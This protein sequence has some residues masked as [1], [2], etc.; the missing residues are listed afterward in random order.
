MIARQAERMLLLLAGLGGCG[1]TVEVAVPETG[2]TSLQGDTT[3]AASTSMPPGS[4]GV[5]AT[6]GDDTTIGGLETGSSDT[7][8]PPPT[9]PECPKR[10]TCGDGIVDP[11][12]GCDD[13]NRDDAD[14]CTNDCLRPS[15]T[16]FAPFAFPSVDVA[17]A[18]DSDGSILFAGGDPAGLI[19]F[20]ID[21][22]VW[23][24]PLELPA[25]ISQVRVNAVLAGPEI[26]VVGNDQNGQ[27]GIAWRFALDGTPLAM[28]PD[29][30]GR[31]YA[32]AGLASDGGLVIG[33]YDSED[34]YVVERRA[35][36]GSVAWSRL[37]E[38]SGMI[39]GVSLAVVS[40]TSVFVAGII[41]GLS[42]MA[43]VHVTPDAA[44]PLVLS[45]P[46]YPNAFLY[47][48]AAA[49]DGGA[50]AVGDASGY[51]IVV[52][53]DPQGELMWISECSAPG[54]RALTVVVEENGILLGGRR[55]NPEC[56]FFSCRGGES[57]LWMQH[58]TLDGTVFA[59]DAPGEL[60]ATHDLNAENVLAL[61]RHPD[62]SV[63]ALCE[64]GSPSEAVFAAQFP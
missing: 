46:E 10:S 25:G 57:W 53:V 2:S 36:D 58:L 12:E 37:T 38:P 16:A 1:P 49:P 43:I 21:A 47:E 62:G 7:G 5:V 4:T 44:T 19:R 15:P 39:G 48:I 45:P 26:V 34:N 59:N 32:G 6:A 8:D 23:A 50:V 42:E 60:L 20:E 28:A 56:G 64:A 61:G 24:V 41:A 14:G 31:A 51:G 11:D 3:T 9:V 17:A 13:A 18:V 22:P 29:P 63:V 54:A 52:R 35:P 33:A 30:L 40:D 55:G 27:T